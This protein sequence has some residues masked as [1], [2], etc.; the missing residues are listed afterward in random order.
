MNSYHLTFKGHTGI[1]NGFSMQVA[2]S[3]TPT[4]SSSEIHQAIIRNGFNEELARR[5]E[6]SG[7]WN[8][9]RL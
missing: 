2:S 5:F 1:P 4:P 8:V 3:F 9:K 6:S 7:N